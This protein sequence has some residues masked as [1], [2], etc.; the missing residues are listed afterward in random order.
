MH[1]SLH[2]S[3]SYIAHTV[4]MHKRFCFNVGR[5]K[6]RLRDGRHCSKKELMCP[7]SK[8]AF[9]TKSLALK[10][11]RK[12]EMRRQKKLKKGLFKGTVLPGLNR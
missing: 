12:T 9:I 6:R 7:P 5:T 3:I 1:F 11:H 2:P 10:L 8:P 4:H